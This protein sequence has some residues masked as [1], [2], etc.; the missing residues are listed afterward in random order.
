MERRKATGESTGG[1]GASR[2]IA[3]LPP[4]QVAPTCRELVSETP[5]KD[6]MHPIEEQL[7]LNKPTNHSV[8]TVVD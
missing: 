8:K 7:W 3:D 4:A 2:L 5:G 6:K 1:H